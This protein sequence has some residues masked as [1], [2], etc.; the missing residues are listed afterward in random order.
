MQIST[1]FAL[2][3]KAGVIDERLIEAP[4]AWDSVYDQI[5]TMNTLDLK[6]YEKKI[7]GPFP[8]T[9]TFSKRMTEH[10]L[11]KLN[12]KRQMPLVIVR[13]SIMGA[14]LDEPFPGWTDSTTYLGGIYLLAGLGMMKEF[15]GDKNTMADIIPVDHVAN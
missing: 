6:H 4:I 14:S 15:P 12:S 2:C 13:P 7:L 3:E 8:N 9:Y 11:H 5:N 10:L 1:C